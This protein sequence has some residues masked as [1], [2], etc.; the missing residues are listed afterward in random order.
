MKQR[1]EQVS[2][3]LPLILTAPAPVDNLP[4][5]KKKRHGNTTLS[6]WEL[7]HNRELYF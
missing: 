7:L 1:N 6:N 2:H 3:W 4:K 5:K